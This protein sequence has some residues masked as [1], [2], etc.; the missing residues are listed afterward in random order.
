MSQKETD[1][2]EAVYGYQGNRNPFIDFPDLAEYVWGNKVGEPFRV[3]GGTTPGGKPVLTAPVADTTLDFGQVAVGQSIKALLFF[4]GENI[5]SS[6]TLT[7][8]G[9]DKAM[10]SIPEKS[11][12]AQLLNAPSGYYLQVT[13][14]P[15]ATGIHQARIAMSDG[16]LEGSMTVN[17]RGEALETPVLSTL[18]AYEAADITSDTYTASWS[19]APEDIDYYVVTR[20]RYTENGDVQT[21]EI[22]CEETSLTITDFDASTQETYSVQSSRLGFRSPA[23]NVVFVYHS[24]LGELVTDTPLTVSSYPGLIRISCPVDHTDARIYDARGQLETIISRIEAPGM[25]LNLEPGVYLM[26]TAEHPT[27][28]KLIAR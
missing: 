4:K 28:V 15:T 23:S 26:V 3:Q 5:P 21:D 24:G 11:I 22:E 2:N 12:G 16:G 6:L 9:A 27:P 10:F 14:T 8:V 20:S 19:K 18:T 17:L 13:Y 1:R 7:L 25:E